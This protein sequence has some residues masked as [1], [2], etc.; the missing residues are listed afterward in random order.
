MTRKHFEAIAAA[1]RF[2]VTA[3]RSFQQH[4][5]GEVADA[6]LAAHTL[7]AQDMARTLAQFNPNFDRSRF[8]VACGV[9]GQ[10]V[11]NE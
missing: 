9:G 10:L 2:N 6:V 5:P 8:L 11:D 1:L 7:S 3:A 4:N